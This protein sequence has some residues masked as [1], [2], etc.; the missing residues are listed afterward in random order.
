MKPGA[1]RSGIPRVS[2]THGEELTRYGFGS[3]HPFAVDRLAIFWSA[4]E[5]RGLADRVDLAAPRRAS[6]ADIEL[7]HDP[8]YVDMVEER[9]ATGGGYLD[10][11]DTPAFRGMYDG[12]AWVVGSTLDAARRLVEGMTRRAFVPVAGLHHARRDRA[13][14]FCIFNDCAVAIEQLRR[15]L[16]G[17]T[18]AYVDIDAHHGDGVYY[19]FEAVP[20][21]VIADIH[22]DG[23][24]LYPGTGD[25]RETGAGAAE[26][27]KLNV[28]VPPGA[29][30]GVFLTA[31]ERVEAFI[32]AAA[33]A[34]IMLQCGADGIAGDPLTHLAYTTASHRLATERLC[35]LADRHCGG[36][37]LALGGGG[38]DRTAMG[39]AWCTV[40][41]AMLE[42]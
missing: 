30:D 37:L 14:G 23:R 2:V 36:R 35:R 13:G 32:D 6:R 26:G 9:S 33:P 4:M 34:F 20:E 39:D 31:W 41:E 5:R 40:V 29:D 17:R 18:V 28:T 25:S 19:G 16:H 38:Y 10:H 42:S 27:T 1:T 11:G 22:E 8:T 21:V 3:G 24:F 7:F 12:A 15:A